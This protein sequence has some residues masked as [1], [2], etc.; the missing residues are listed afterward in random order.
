MNDRLS[1]KASSFDYG[2]LYKDI[3]DFRISLAPLIDRK[4]ILKGII[5]RVLTYE[6][7]AMNE[8][9]FSQTIDLVNK[10]IKNMSDEFDFQLR[11]CA[12][13]ITQ[14]E[15]VDEIIQED[16]IEIRMLAEVGYKKNQML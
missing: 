14:V 16:L 12:Q 2:T 4:L 9:D 8:T 13:R 6:T 1:K 5:D 7:N 10:N 11:G 15:A 3:A